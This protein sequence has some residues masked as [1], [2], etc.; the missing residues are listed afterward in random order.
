MISTSAPTS[1][2]H[3]ASLSPSR[4]HLALVFFLCPLRVLAVCAVTM[5]AVCPA[6]AEGPAP[7]KREHP[8]SRTPI[9]NEQSETSNTRSASTLPQVAPALLPGV[10]WSPVYRRYSVAELVVTGVFAAGI[11]V[12][13]IIG[14]P[15]SGPRGGEWIDEDV[16]DALRAQAYRGR[17]RAKDGSD[18]LLSLSVSYALLGD[19]M[20]NAS[21]LRRSPD[22]GIQMGLINAE[23]LAVTLGIQEVTANLVGR[24]RPYGSIC[25]SDELDENT[26]SCQ[27]RNR[28]RSFFSGH[29]SVPFAMAASTCMHHVFIPL[30]GNHAWLSCSL[31]FLIAGSSGALRIASDNHYATDVLTGAAFGTLVGLTIPLLHYVRG[32]RWSA[33]AVATTTWEIVPTWGGLSVQGRFL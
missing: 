20:I 27:G 23:V 21:W 30:V 8:P 5:L 33:P 14:P 29:T 6:R 15:E 12:G 26:H 2:V 11:A 28:Y 4:Q 31:G 24:E 32:N 18:V 1:P 3:G 7:M 25:G 13:R 9:A 22:V 19:P 16:R 10:K 17:L